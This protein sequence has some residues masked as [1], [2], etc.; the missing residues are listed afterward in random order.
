MDRLAAALE[1]ANKLKAVELQI[2]LGNPDE[3]RR[4]LNHLYR[5]GH[6]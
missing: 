3:A 1:V 4:E 5:R 2:A 6:V